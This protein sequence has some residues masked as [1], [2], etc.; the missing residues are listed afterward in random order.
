M[1]DCAVIKLDLNIHELKFAPTVEYVDHMG[2]DTSVVNAARVSFA[3]EV[4]EMS[5]KDEKLIKYLAAHKHWTPFAHTS[6]TLRMGAPIFLARQL[7]K[8]QVGGVWN[9]ESRR[10]I[11]D[12][13]SFYIPAEWHRAPEGSIKQGSGDT[14][15]NQ[16]AGH[17]ITEVSSVYRHCYDAYKDL[18]AKGLAPE[19]A[20]MVLP[21]G[22]VTHWIWTGSLM[23]WARV[24]HLRADSHAQKDLQPFV[25][26]LDEIMTKLYPISWKYLKEYWN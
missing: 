17:F 9:E 18:L 5:D 22:A 7:S 13:V 6:V 3:K 24:Y 14:F 23:F 21:Q 4:T 19:Q 15:S 26:K 25:E 20:R 12:N 8:H 1:D 2:D 10:Y 11:T 16:I